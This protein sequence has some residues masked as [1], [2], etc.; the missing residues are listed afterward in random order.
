MK[1]SIPSANILNPY[2]FQIEG[3]V[4]TVVEKSCALLLGIG[5]GKTVTGLTVFQVL[6]AFG[7]AQSMLVISS[8]RVI[9][10][11]W[12]TE[13]KKW[14]HT[15]GLKFVNLRNNKMDFSEPADVYLLNYESIPKLYQKL[16]NK[17][18]PVQ[19]IVFDESH[20]IQDTK[21]I[22]YR[23]MRTLLRRSP[24]MYK[25]ILTG[26]PATEHLLNLYGQFFLLDRG[27]C[28]GSTLTS[29][30][31]R[32]FSHPS[33]YVWKPKSKKHVDKIYQ[34]ISGKCVRSPANYNVA[35]HKDIDRI[36]HLPKKA[37]KIYKKFEQ[38]A[39]LELQETTIAAFSVVSVIMKSR[40]LAQG[41]MYDEDGNPHWIH[42][43]KLT[44]LESILNEV[45]D[46]QL[47]I[48]VGYRA[49]AIKLEERFGFRVVNSAMTS[50]DKNAS[51][52]RFKS[53]KDRLLF[54]NPKSLAE[55]IDGLQHICRA[56]VWYTLTYSRRDYNQLIGRVNRT[57]QK[58]TV[59]SIRLIAQDT[60]D[61]ALID[62]LKAKGKMADDLTDAVIKYLGV[63]R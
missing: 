54:V 13:A 50:Q 7:E 25:M 58:H 18:I 24:D 17:P 48:A 37:F 16:R 20:R 11:V 61:H 41:F 43:S 4:K 56:V 60:I 53:G 63:K 14:I 62:V 5:D 9:D 6:R 45:P 8:I 46:Q 21:S 1:T 3:A 52:K 31:E 49:E 39:V 42:E 40:T 15:S 59:N 29:F 47:I 36:I 2:G 57:G 51:I 19:L 30:R 32:Y 35:P 44:E 26:D 23:R 55:G 38:T 27:K 33:M 22:R 10:N 28:L 12:H 34:K